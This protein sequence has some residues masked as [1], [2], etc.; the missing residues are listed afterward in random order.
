MCVSMVLAGAGSAA[1]PRPL[2]RAFTDDVWYDANGGPWVTRTV[3]TG[4]KMV[5][6][7][8]DW[9]EVA[10]TMPRPVYDP[11][12][13]SD[14]QYDFGYLDAVLRKF[15]GAGISPAFMVTDAPRWAEAP[16]G[17]ADLEADGAWNPA[18]TPYGQLATALARRYSGSYPDPL[19]PG[20]MLPRVQYFQA[21][22][23]ANF[24]IHLAP[25]WVNS[26]GTWVPTGPAIY[27]N[28]LN[29]FYAGIKEG[30][31]SAMVVTAGFGPFGDPPGACP[32]GEVGN[33]CRMPP[34]LFVRSLL[35]FTGQALKQQPCSNP[36]HFDALAQDPYEVGPPTLKAFN[37]DDVSAPD[38]GKLTRIVNKAVTVGT[39]LPRSHKQLWVTE[40][41]YDSNPPNPTA[42]STATQA[43]WLEESFY[44]FWTEGVSDVVWYLVRDQVPGNW[45]TTY[46]SGVFFYNGEPKPAFEAF[47]FPF[48]VMPSGRRAVVWGISPRT[49]TLAVQRQ[50]GRSW[51]TVFELRVTAGGV[52]TREIAG[53]LRGNFRG[54]V[55]GEPSRAWNR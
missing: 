52:F 26:G 15:A 27:R 46:H 37:A 4:A 19:F 7:E 20:R 36:A 13:P 6:L 18:P 51:K 49:G 41:S 24:D 8:V 40:F 11:T 33:G 34:A 42:V 54:V 53:S 55:K 35:C 32:V 5:L 30:N 48:V 17:P 23:E 31:R 14:P 39:V 29:A 2:T 44:I 10:P 47:R 21:W 25:Q 16:G 22:A 3:A 9:A 1:A 38:L 45:S 50:R 43:K 28:L 12:S